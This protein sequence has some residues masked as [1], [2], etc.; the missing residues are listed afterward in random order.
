[1]YRA[2]YSAGIT[3]LVISDG[4]RDNFCVCVCRQHFQK[5]VNIQGSWL[6]VYPGDQHVYLHV[7]TCTYLSTC[8]Q[9]EQRNAL[10]N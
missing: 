5:K 1:M 3:T 4:M 9:N 10:Q 8:W 2:Q 7:Y 6:T